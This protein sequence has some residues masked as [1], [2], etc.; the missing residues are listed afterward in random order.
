MNIFMILYHLV[1]G[2]LS[3]MRGA[4]LLSYLGAMVETFPRRA[5]L[6]A[7][8]LGLSAASLFGCAP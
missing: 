7:F 1:A 8:L 6:T 2:A 5:A 4:S 3:R